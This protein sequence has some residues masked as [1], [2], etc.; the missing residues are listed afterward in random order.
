MIDKEF[1]IDELRRVTHISRRRAVV[2]MDAWLN[3]GQLT[4]DEAKAQVLAC[5]RG[6][7][8]PIQTA[9]IARI[10]LRVLER[11]HGVG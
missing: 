8:D 10:I 3:A 2:Y 4:V 7:L 11:E 1:V 9:L 5:L 6:G